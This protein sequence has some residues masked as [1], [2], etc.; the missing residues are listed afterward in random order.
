MAKISSYIWASF[1]G[2]LKVASLE[3]QNGT[4]NG[5][6]VATRLLNFTICILMACL[7]AAAAEVR[8]ARLLNRPSF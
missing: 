5:G 7:C 1:P 3:I 4:I 2:R 8:R 6:H